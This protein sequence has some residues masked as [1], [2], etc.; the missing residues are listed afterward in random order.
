MGRTLNTLGIRLYY[1][2]RWDEAV[3]AYRR[4]REA[5]ARA[6]DVVGEATLANNEGEV[7]S[8]Q[9]RLDEAA[10]P[11]HHFVRVCKAVGYPLGEGA[12]VSN[13][14]RLEARASRFE[15]AHDLFAQALAIM[16]RIGAARFAAEARARRGECL[17]FEGSH[18]EAIAL[19][20][21]RV[22]DGEVDPVSILVE[23]SLG[24]A[25]HQA[26]RP[27]EARPHF[28]KSLRLARELKAEYEVALTLRAM[29]ATRYPSDED[30]AAE[31]DAI[32]E[33]LGV[34]SVPSVPLP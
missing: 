29:A 20:D 27:E 19:L 30:L 4:G 14:G 11:F 9:G 32:L 15:E 28:E 5:L 21:G 3:D 31:S 33:R 10:D 34:V 17:V 23:R 12:A 25:L 24:Y 18:A 13:L 22:A 2:G 26:R 16:E 7:L 8:D 1:E 6:G